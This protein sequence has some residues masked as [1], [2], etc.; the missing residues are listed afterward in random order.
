MASGLTVEEV[1]ILVAAVTATAQPVN[2]AF[3]WRLLLKDPADDMV[4]ETA[5]NGAADILVT[6]NLRD[7]RG[8]AERFGV[9]VLTPKQMLRRMV[10]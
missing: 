2:L 6:F 9:E 5:I 3:R 10:Q 1:L 8:V 7:F 4:L